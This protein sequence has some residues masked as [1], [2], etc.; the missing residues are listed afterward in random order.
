MGFNVNGLLNPNYSEI[1]QDTGE[2]LLIYGG[3]GAGKSYS[4]ADKL[5]LQSITQPANIPGIKGDRT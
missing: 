4:I 1:F 2:E 5:L 3:A